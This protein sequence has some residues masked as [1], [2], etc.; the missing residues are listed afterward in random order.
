[1]ARQV[2][3][4]IENS[5]SYKEF[6]YFFNTYSR[7]NKNVEHIV[8]NV[9]RYIFS[10]S[11]ANTSSC[12]RRMAKL[13]ILYNKIDDIETPFYLSDVFETDLNF[14][15]GLFNAGIIERTGR[16]RQCRNIE[17]KTENE[18]HLLLY[19]TFLREILNDIADYINDVLGRIYTL[20]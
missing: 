11:S 6:E 16:I 4:F 7:H 15:V 2:T 18:Y 5:N 12:L 9:F 10:G 3:S 17:W 20:I 13:A 14:S 1:M 8:L 19:P